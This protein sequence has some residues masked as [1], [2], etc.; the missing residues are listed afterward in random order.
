MACTRQ[1]L[2]CSP[3]PMLNKW[4]HCSVHDGMFEAAKNVG[5][6]TKLKRIERSGIEPRCH[7]ALAECKNDGS[8]KGKCYWHGGKL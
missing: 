5:E 2:A 4:Q 8:N 6:Y 7:A 3:R 1:E